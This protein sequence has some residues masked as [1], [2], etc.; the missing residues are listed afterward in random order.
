MHQAWLEHTRQAVGDETFSALFSAGRGMTMDQAVAYALHEDASAA[1][2]ATTADMKPDAWAPLTPREQEVARLVASGMANR[3]IASKLV[4][5]PAT[6]AKH[7]EHI[8]EKLGL[9]SRTQI[10]AWV[11]EHD[12]A[13]A[14]GG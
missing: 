6:A 3:Q 11:L 10:A 4:V 5:T 12:A 1:Q 9:T 2:Q 7:V 14:R 13:A 8:R